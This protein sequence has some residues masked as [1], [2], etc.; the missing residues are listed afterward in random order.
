MGIICPDR[1]QAD[2]LLTLL[3]RRVVREQF[4]ESY[5]ALCLFTDEGPPCLELVI[6]EGGPLS[7]HNRGAGGIHHIALQ[8]EDLEAVSRELGDRGIELL[9]AEPVDA[10]PIW[11]NFISPIYTRGLTVEVVQPRTV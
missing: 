4:V 11:I 1:E 7:R 2:L 10:G 8:V 5:Q 9:E 6:P 3:G